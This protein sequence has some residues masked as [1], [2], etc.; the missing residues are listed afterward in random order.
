MVLNWT[1]CLI[2]YAK[3]R[4]M[5]VLR[6]GF[7]SSLVLL[8]SIHPYIVKAGVA[9]ISCKTIDSSDYWLIADVSLKCWHNAHLKYVLTL[10]LPMLLLLIL[11]IP[12]AIALC[13][14]RFRRTPH[15]NLFAFFTVGYTSKDWWEIVIC[16]GKML[17]ILLLGLVGSSEA[18][19]QIL[20]AMVVLYS[21]L[22]WH[23][24]AKP[25]K[26]VFHSK[27]EGFS[28]FLQ[29]VLLGFS[30][31]YT[32]ELRV[33]DIILKVASPRL[34]LHFYILYSLAW[35]QKAEEFTESAAGNAQCFD[36][37]ASAYMLPRY[38]FSR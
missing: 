37:N 27:L 6:G 18:I 21:L 14:A 23:I 33:A 36:R 34:Y 20:C 28:L 1:V 7:Q 11:G 13:V 17:L 38:Q 9:L 19:I 30:Y 35:A 2:M 4:S 5:E 22:E 25:F 10:F 8:Y 29:L 16:G 31:Y 32:A 15:R 12:I 24:R 3:R 26:E